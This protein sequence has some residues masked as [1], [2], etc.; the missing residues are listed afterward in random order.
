MLN[1]GAILNACTQAVIRFFTAKY[2]ISKLYPN[3][4][5]FFYGEI[6]NFKVAPKRP[7]V[8]LQGI[9]KI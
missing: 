3:G 2:E 8:F 4:H 7:S 9:T 1:S 5:S 6:R